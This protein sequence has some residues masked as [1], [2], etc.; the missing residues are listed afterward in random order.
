MMFEG[1]D[2]S[3]SLNLRL[4]F[5]FYWELLLDAPPRLSYRRL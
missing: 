1:P 4:N 3:F 2:L 5:F